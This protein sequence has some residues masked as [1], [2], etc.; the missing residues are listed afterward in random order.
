MNVSSSSRLYKF[1]MIYR[2]TREGPITT[3]CDLLFSIFGTLL[4]G[5]GTYVITPL[6]LITAVGLAFKIYADIPPAIDFIAELKLTL[7]FGFICTVILGTIGGAATYWISK[8]ICDKIQID[9]VDA[10]SAEG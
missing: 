4:I 8:N 10:A 3:G 6:A 5:L 1:A 9:P 2:S 7:Y